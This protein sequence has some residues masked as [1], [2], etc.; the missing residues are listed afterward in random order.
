ML[1]LRVIISTHSLRYSIR[2][3]TTRAMSHHHGIDVSP[4]IARWMKDIDTFDRSVFQRSVRVLG[5]RVPIAKTAE[6][7]R[8]P[9]LRRFVPFLFRLCD[10]VY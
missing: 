7:L 1:L 10:Y 2:R 8:S 9:T 6:M 3:V 5:A 4:P